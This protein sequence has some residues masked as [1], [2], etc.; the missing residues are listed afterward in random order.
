M[1]ISLPGRFMVLLPHQ[2]LAGISRKIEDE[3]IQ[4]GARVSGRVLQDEELL[5][6]VN[7]LVEYPVALC[8][9]FDRAF[10][11]LPREIIIHSMKEH[12]RYFP[13]E[14]E[15]GRLLPHFVCISNTDPKDQ[16][17]VVRGNERVLK[18]RL[19]DAAFF[20]QDDL[21]IP[22]ENRL[23]QLKKVVLPA[24]LGPMIAVILPVSIDK[25]T[26]S[27]ATSP[28]KTLVRLLVSSITDPLTSEHLSVLT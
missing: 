3:M 20:F 18:A 28:P 11:S 13:V 10:L 7:F 4:E 14:D 17:V 8:G 24:P 5:D 1:N 9:N 2:D 22:L 12:Q 27:R 19:S 23:E 16:K 6:E 15:Q 25:S 21:K 26:L